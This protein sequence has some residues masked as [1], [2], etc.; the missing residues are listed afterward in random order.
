MIQYQQNIAREITLVV[1][2][3]GLLMIAYNGIFGA[4]FPT[5]QGTIGNDYGLSL[6]GLVD[7]FIWHAKNGLWEVPWFTPSFC[8]GQ[9]LFADPQSGY[10]SVPQWL[11][12]LTNPLSASYLTLLLF[13]T[14]GFFGIYLLA[15][16]FFELSPS[17][18][19]LAASLYLFNG[20]L[21][22]RMIEGHT[23]YHG[24]TLAPWLAVLLLL[25]AA[26]R[27][28]TLGLGMIAGCIATYWLQSGLTT[29][30]LPASL[31]V[32]VI[33]LLYRLRQ[34]WPR[35]LVI[36]ALTAVTVSLLLCASKLVA[37]LSFYS[38][39][40]RTQYLL[41]GFDNPIALLFANLLALFFPSKTAALVGE[42]WLVNAQWSLLPHE[43]AFGFTVV[44]I[45]ALTRARA[46][47]RGA[48][49]ESELP[50]PSTTKADRAG[51]LTTTAILIGI[52][53]ILLIPIAIQFYTPTL[54]AWYKSMPLIGATVAPMR[55]LIIYL[56]FIPIATALL[57]QR[58]LNGR[59]DRATHLVAG[60]MMVLIGLT[61]AEFRLYFDAPTYRP[62][63]VLAGY[64]QLATGGTKNHRLQSIGMMTDPITGETIS[65]G[66]RNDIVVDGISQMGC[67]NPSFGYRLEKLPPGGMIIGD[68]LLERDGFLNIR[69]PSCY[70]Y[71][72][73]NGC[74][75][76]DRFRIDQRADAE[77]F[78]SYKPFFFSK[79]S[80]QLAA[81]WSTG[82]SLIFISCFILLI[83]PWHTWAE[84]QVTSVF[85]GSESSASIASNSRIPL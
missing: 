21:A 71:P 72:I 43:W 67:Y 77:A 9:P 34:P 4:F 73:E 75:P 16:R 8:G 63:K 33:L 50:D 79:S 70:V 35:D 28:A 18:A 84:R 29:L 68:V 45:L 64:Q 24:L 3:W 83:W 13:A 12:F 57:A 56:P 25:P 80:A 48:K 11:T 44:P 61:L 46:L 31:S 36:R 55:W 47:A 42:Q 81:D 69:N 20:F 66:R 38:Q 40:E 10:Y 39:F 6:S 22:H 5:S 85:S 1:I 17:W 62:D 19:I 23:G 52:A 32:S 14:V 54:N 26:N 60:L 76:G 82:L 74:Q 78:V 51:L 65:D 15:R 7:G 53:V 2:V 37:S 49:S 58:S 41:P 30:M 27:M 59:Q